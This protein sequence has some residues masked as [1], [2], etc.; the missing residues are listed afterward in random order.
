[1]VI[2]LAFCRERKADLSKLKAPA[3]M[4]RNRLDGRRI[5]DRGSSCKCE[6]ETSG[7]AAL[8]T[9]RRHAAL[10]MGQIRSNTEF[11]LGHR[12]LVWQ[13]RLRPTTILFCP[14]ARSEVRAQEAASSC[15]RPS[16]RIAA[17][18]RWHACS[19]RLSRACP[20]SRCGKHGARQVGQRGPLPAGLRSSVDLGGRSTEIL[21]FC[22]SWH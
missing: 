7:V 10:S 2:D 13:P 4:I 3:T 20:T 22:H 16:A 17:W 19:Q 15:V 1:M 5:I 8:A 11:V 21:L 14:D 12:V 6:S 9:L 18:C